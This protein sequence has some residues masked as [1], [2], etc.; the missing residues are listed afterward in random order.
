MS[1]IKNNLSEI[2]I[3]Q[4]F[5]VIKKFVSYNLILVTDQVKLTSIIVL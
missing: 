5:V 1:Q 2:L 3:N 4:I